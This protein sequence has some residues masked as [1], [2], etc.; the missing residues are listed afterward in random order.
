[1]I[2]LFVAYWLIY[3]IISAWYNC[4]FIEQKD[5]HLA[6]SFV[7]A[8]TVLGVV[9]SSKF[10]VMLY[11]WQDSCYLSFIAL[12]LRWVFFDL[13]L[14]I[15]RNQKWY[16]IGSTSWIDKNLMHWQFLFK[17]LFLFLSLCMCLAYSGIGN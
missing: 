7:A 16:Y 4:R 13:A 3:W 11:S 17:V 15:M 9:L 10:G 1:M 2:L 6:G 5:F 12:T 8:L 14:N